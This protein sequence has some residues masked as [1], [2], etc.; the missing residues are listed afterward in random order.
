MHG[1]MTLYDP[2]LDLMITSHSD[3]VFGSVILFHISNTL[4]WLYPILWSTASVNS[5]Y[6]IILILD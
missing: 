5:E 3:L 6:D 1:I 2:V 4:P